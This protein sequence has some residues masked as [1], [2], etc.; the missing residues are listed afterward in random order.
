MVQTTTLLLATLLTLTSAFQSPA[1]SF[2]S[3]VSPQVKTTSSSSS[4]LSAA[5]VD[6]VTGVDRN[7]NFAKLAGGYVHQAAVTA[8]HYITHRLFI[9]LLMTSVA[10]LQFQHHPLNMTR[11]SLKPPTTTTTTTKQWGWGGGAREK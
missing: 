4:A 7:A 9:S 2:A 5:T 1:T 11:A 3:V 10:T 8:V 6:G